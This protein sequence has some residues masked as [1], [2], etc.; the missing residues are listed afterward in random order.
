MGFN[1]SLTYAG[2]NVCVDAEKQYYA[3]LGN[4]YFTA[5]HLNEKSYDLL[6]S[7]NGVIEGD[8]TSLVNYL[9]PFQESGKIEYG[10][11]ESPY[12][13]L[14]RFDYNY[15]A[16][17]KIMDGLVQEF[18]NL[19]V[20]NKCARCNNTDN[21]NLY[22]TKDGVLPLCN[23]CVKNIEDQ[24]EIQNKKANHYII[25]FIAAL[26][27]ALIGSVLLFFVSFL[28]IGGKI[29]LALY[30]IGGFLTGF[31]STKAYFLVH[32]KISK[33]GTI[34]VLLSIVIG[35]GIIF[36][37]EFG[38]QIKNLEPSNSFQ[39]CLKS[40]PLY[41][42]NK[43]NRILFIVKYILGGGSGLILG[44]SYMIDAGSKIYFIKKINK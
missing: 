3:K 2:F 30:F 6:I 15:E 21:I 26:L 14:F 13:I 12:E 44:L 32:G 16:L 43:D 19:D 9:T 7:F 41:M 29:G 25:G 18:D 24:I 42:Q 35:S 31:V 1:E 17:K 20:I 10:F 33:F 27:G 11:V 5:K 22:R 36:Y 38:L 34:L 37:L 40:I 8:L 4:Y 28:G 39:E 23:Y